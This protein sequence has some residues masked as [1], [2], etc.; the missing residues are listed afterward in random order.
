MGFRPVPPGPNL[1]ALIYVAVPVSK[2]LG[3]KL[4]RTLC[5]SNPGRKPVKVPPR[6]GCPGGPKILYGSCSFSG[7]ILWHVILTRVSS[8]T[9]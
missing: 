7:T 5:V 8:A 4:G 9:G 3:V 2:F 6:L 1:T